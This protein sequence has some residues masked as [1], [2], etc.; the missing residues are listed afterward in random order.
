MADNTFFAF[1]HRMKYI[2]RWGLMRNTRYDNL[3]EHSFDVAS[4]ALGIAKIGNLY[5]KKDYDCE[6]I[7]VASLFHD[8][9]ETITGDMPTPIKYENEEITKAYKKLEYEAEKQI[10]NMLPVDLKKE[11]EPYFKVD[12]KSKAVIK[13]AD[14]IS[15]YIKCLEEQEAGNHDFSSAKNTLEKS[16]QKI[17]LPEVKRF[18]NDYLPP[19]T[20]TLDQLKK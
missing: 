11:Y 19:Y 4:I 12:D 16:L 5:Y 10:L 9:N 14:K 7:V 17:E 6:K 20:M 3:K 2:N 15:A 8:A 1:I 18:M 13:A